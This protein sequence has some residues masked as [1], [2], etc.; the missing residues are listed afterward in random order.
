[1]RNRRIEN[2]PL[3]LCQ[4]GSRNREKR[5][6]FVWMSIY[7][8]QLRE[9]P[10]DVIMPDLSLVRFCLGFSRKQAEHFRCAE[11]YGTCVL[12]KTVRGFL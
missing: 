11:G 7:V 6:S 1:M 8:L 4:A 10:A 9:S 3:H 12:E 5:L 2:H